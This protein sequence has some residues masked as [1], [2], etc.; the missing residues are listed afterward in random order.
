[1]TDYNVSAEAAKFN[2]AAAEKSPPFKAGDAPLSGR[3]FLQLQ[4]PPQR[5]LVPELIPEGSIFAIAARPQVGKTPWAHQVAISVAAGEPWCEGAKPSAKAEVLV[6]GLERGP[7]LLQRQIKAQ[8]GD[9]DLPE[10]MNFHFT[11]PRVNK[12]G[13]EKL[14]AWLKDHPAVKLVLV[15]HWALLKPEDGRE[16]VAAYDDDYKAVM[17][18]RELVIEFGVSFIL[19]MHAN[20]S[21][22]HVDMLA[23]FYGN[24]GFVGAVDVRA[25]L[26]RSGKTV[27]GKLEWGGTEVEPQVKRL[28]FDY[29]KWRPM[30]AEDAAE[31]DAAEEGTKTTAFEA[32]RRFGP[33]GARHG[34]WLAESGLKA[35]TF[36]RHRQALIDENWVLPPNPTAPP[37]ERVYIAMV[38]GGV[39][40]G[41]ATMRPAPGRR[42]VEKELGLA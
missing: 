13:A 28:V 34:E 5:F 31:E 2:G 26:S 38:Q 3:D 7:H 20:Q 21:K 33:G 42:A 16:G 24:T 25:F 23:A 9:G 40:D 17:F 8:L 29:P 14:R 10:G 41:P 36:N 18:L 12:G 11:W 32:L 22:E 15:D 27:K 37:K 4:Y 35:S 30:G 19:V 1:M 39:N 6:L